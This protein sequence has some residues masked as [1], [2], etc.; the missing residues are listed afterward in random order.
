[1][2][3]VPEGPDG[4]LKVLG[5]NTPRRIQEKQVQHFYKADPKYGEGVAQGLG[6]KID[7]VMNSELASA[8]R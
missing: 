1:M 7:E 8:Q 4:P 3:A 5:L 2:F 6:L